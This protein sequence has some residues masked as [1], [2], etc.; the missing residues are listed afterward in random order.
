VYVYFHLGV[1][2]YVLFTLSPSCGLTTLVILLSFCTFCTKMYVHFYVHF[3]SLLFLLSPF[4]RY[5]PK[6]VDTIP[7]SRY[8]IYFLFIFTFVCSSCVFFVRF[9]ILIKKLYTHVR[10]VRSMYAYCTFTLSFFARFHLR[11]KKLYTHVRSTKKIMGVIPTIKK[12]YRFDV[13]TTLSS[14]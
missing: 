6:Q 3:Y 14:G 5:Y 7:L 13:V 12:I 11:I 2:F 9:L 8:Y 1:H 4:S 10:S